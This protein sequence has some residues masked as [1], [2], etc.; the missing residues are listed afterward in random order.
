[1]SPLEYMETVKNITL[2]E[3]TETQDEIKVLRETLTN[4]E[5]QAAILDD[6]L[7]SCDEVITIL[8]TLTPSN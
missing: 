3:Q 4:A 5:E 2:A 6:Y 7:K 8:K 1:M